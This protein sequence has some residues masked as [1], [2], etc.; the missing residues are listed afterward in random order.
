MPR[1]TPEKL[2]R[3]YDQFT[4]NDPV[5]IVINADPDAIASAMAVSRLLWRRVLNVT[6]SNINIIKR[7]D[8]LAMIRLLGVSLTPFSEIDPAQFSRTVM[9]DSQPDH[10]ELLVPLEPDVIID[11]HPESAIKAPFLDIRPNYGAT[12][13]I[14][15][16]YLRSARI[17]P[18]VKLATGLFHAIKTDTNDFKGKTLI[19]DVRAFQYLFRHA[20]IHLARKIEQAD[21]RFDFLKYFKIALNNMRLYKKKVFVHLGNV[22]SPDILVIIADFFMRINSVTWSIVSGTCD[23]KLVIIFRNDGIRK[24]AGKLAKNAFGQLGSAGGHKNM[25]RAEMALSELID[26]IDT[27]DDKK[28]LRWII[29]KTEKK[30]KKK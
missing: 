1:S 14:M 29:R 20:N 4:G 19:E 26:H 17:K 2:R 8:N 3:F 22:A 23:K 10:N 5:L 21:L 13:T 12:A 18:S 24:N 28:L 6:I 30:Q 16:E 15:T 9:V 7:P 25:A 11:H 27:K